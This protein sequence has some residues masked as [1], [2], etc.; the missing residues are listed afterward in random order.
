MA[1]DLNVVINSDLTTLWSLSAPALTVVQILDF[2]PIVL[3]QDEEAID[4][5]EIEQFYHDDLPQP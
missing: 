2:V 4:I 5:A 1:S 3:C